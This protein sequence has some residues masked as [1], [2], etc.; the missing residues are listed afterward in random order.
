MLKEM[1]RRTQAFHFISAGILLALAAAILVWLAPSL[2]LLLKGP[3]DLYAYP[4][5]EL[6]G[7]YVEV[8]ADTLID[9]Y[10]ETVQTSDSGT[11]KTT[12]REYVLVAQD[13]FM[14]MEV[15]A[16]LFDDAEAVLNNT[17]AWLMDTDGSFVDDGSTVTVTGTVRRMDAET[18]QYFMEVMG[19]WLDDTSDCYPLVLRCG[20]VGALE[21]GMHNFWLIVCAVLAVCGV[22]VLAYHF[23]NSRFRQIKAYCAAQ[24][25]PEGTMQEL[26]RFYEATPAGHGVR[27]DSRW[28]VG[29]KGDPFVLAVSDVAW[30]YPTVTRHKRYFIT[31]STTY[32]VNICSKSEKRGKRRH[33]VPVRTEQEGQELMRAIHEV[34]PDA[35]YGYDAAWERPYEADPEAFCRTILAQRRSI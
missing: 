34:A 12:H 7:R 21:P 17:T 13:G 5:A 29:D 6:E 31:V 35:V 33:A 20:T 3:E 27:L 28:I 11:E 26:D 24:P 9:W 1:R 16:S 30:V 4:T 8:D 14:G 15:P 32:A 23:G 19:Y 2:S 22:W 18:E 25:D 10:A